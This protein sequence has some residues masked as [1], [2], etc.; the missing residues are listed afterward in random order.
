MSAEQLLKATILSL[1]PTVFVQTW[2]G[3]TW[4]AAPDSALRGASLYSMIFRP[5]LYMILE[6]ADEED[7]EPIDPIRVQFKIQTAKQ[8][9]VEIAA[10]EAELEAAAFAQE[11]EVSQEQLMEWS[12]GRQSRS[13]TAAKREATAEIQKEPPKKSTKKRARKIDENDEEYL[14]VKK[15]TRKRT[16]K[17]EDKGAAATKRSRK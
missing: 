7:G 1:C 8:R 12:Q 14:P 17:N 5:E 3:G 4:Y 6:H 2:A 15:K 9:E 11:E 16:R 13:R 10:K